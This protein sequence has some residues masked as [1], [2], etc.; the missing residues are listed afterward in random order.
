M[1]RSGRVLANGTQNAS[2]NALRQ[3]D[4]VLRTASA[5]P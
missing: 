3:L 5:R 4:A 1:D 2:P